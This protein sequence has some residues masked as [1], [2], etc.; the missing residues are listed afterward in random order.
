MQTAASSAYP[1]VEV[2]KTPGQN[3]VVKNGRF[4]LDPPA[5]PD[6]SELARTETRPNTLMVLEEFCPGHQ[7]LGRQVMLRRSTSCISCQI[8]RDKDRS[9]P[10]ALPCWAR[11][12]CSREMGMLSKAVPP[13]RTS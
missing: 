10:D 4:C 13:A 7:R 9:D 11:S 2:S 12:E 1:T 3:L 6:F 8:H 5:L